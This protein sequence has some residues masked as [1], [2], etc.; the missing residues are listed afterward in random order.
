MMTTFT[1]PDHEIDAPR[2]EAVSQLVQASAGEV[3]PAAVILIARQGEVVYQRGFGEIDAGVGVTPRQTRF[4][5]AS[6]TKLFTLTALLRLVADGLVELDTP[7]GEVLPAFGGERPIGPAEDPIAKVPLPADPQ[8]EGQR[9]RLETITLRHLLTHNS[10][11]A[12]WRSVYA[13]GEP[14]RPVPMPHAVPPALRRERMA[15]VYG[16][17]FFY[18]TGQKILY[19]DL[20]FMLLGEAVARLGGAPLDHCI[21]RLVCVPLELWDSGYN[22]LKH[23]LDPA[24]IA[25]TEF[26]AW[27]ERRCRGEV[28]DENAAGL[29]GVSGHAGMF[30]TVADLVR[31]GQVYLSG[32]RVNDEQWLPADLVAESVREQVA[33]GGSRRGLGW[34]LQTEQD[35]ACGSLFGRGSF[36]HTGFTGTSLWI[37][38]DRKLLVAALTNRVY[39]GRDPDGILAFRP[40]VHDAVVQAL[41]MA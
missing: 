2:F 7:V 16:Y 12:A 4:D 10:G 6:L 37:D 23:G 15:A 38:P 9:V 25:P 13:V 26:C 30:S 29:G 21:R 35:C 18:P 41:E 34:V 36:G 3:Y 22:P 33:L 14:Q 39:Y 11:L 27:R 32:G 17:D 20:G 8:Y 40:R 31:L 1:V 19:S 5:L 28:H 24:A